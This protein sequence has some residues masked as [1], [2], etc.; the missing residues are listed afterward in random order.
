MEGAAMAV[1]LIL[2]VSLNVRKRAVFCK[3]KVRLKSALKSDIRQ[4][5]R[6]KLSDVYQLVL[7]SRPPMQML[8]EQSPTLSQNPLF[9]SKKL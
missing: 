5:F 1:R 3:G 4:H 7:K 2:S 6:M 8:V 9:G